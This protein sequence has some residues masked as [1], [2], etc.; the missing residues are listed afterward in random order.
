MVDYGTATIKSVQGSTLAELRK[1]GRYDKVFP[2]GANNISSAYKQ[3][4]EDFFEEGSSEYGGSVD[5]DKEKL[6]QTGAVWTARR[7]RHVSSAYPVSEESS[8]SNI[9]KD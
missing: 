1:S 2:K 6:E 9:S 3:V 5:V 4:G 8:L 7:D